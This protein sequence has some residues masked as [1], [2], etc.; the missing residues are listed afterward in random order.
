MKKIILLAFLVLFS[1]TKNQEI[2]NIDNSNKLSVKTEK[3]IINNE[4]FILEKEKISKDI[5]SWFS[6]MTLDDQAI[7]KCEDIHPIYDWIS[8]KEIKIRSDFIETCNS[9]KQQSQKELDKKIKDFKLTD[10]EII[11]KKQFEDSKNQDNWFLLEQINI[12]EYNIALKNWCELL[13]DETKIKKC[14]EYKQLQEKTDKLENIENF[15]LK[16]FL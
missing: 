16:S 6:K 10:C 3:E 1:C 2:Q 5:I 4:N 7:Y 9:L 13:K 12:C 11:I 8:Q 14:E 15:D